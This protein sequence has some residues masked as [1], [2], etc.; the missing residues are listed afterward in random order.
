M[1]KSTA[2]TPGREQHSSNTIMG[3]YHDNRDGVCEKLYQQWLEAELARMKR[4]L[5]RIVKK[6]NLQVN[7]LKKPDVVLRDYNQYPHKIGAV[8]KLEVKFEGKTVLTPIYVS[9]DSE[10]RLTVSCIFGTNLLFSLGILRES[11]GVERS[12]CIRKY[13]SCELVCQQSLQKL[14]DVLTSPTV[15]VYLDFSKPFVLRTDASG[16]GL[17]AVLELIQDDGT[18][19]SIAYA[20]S[21]VS[22]HERRYGI[23]ELEALGAVRTLKH[24]RAHIWGH[25]TT[26]YT[27]HSL[28]RSLFYAKHSCG[29][30]ARWSKAVS[31]YDLEIHYRPGRQNANADA[32]FR[33]PLQA[34]MGSSSLET[35]QIATILYP[36]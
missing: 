3:Q 8:A 16:E 22:P 29:K 34:N 21:T 32:M 9:V 35:I 7:T 18:S 11:E 25:K 27:D 28:V 33:L 17:G 10:T 15:L 23:T 24:F 12:Y 26:L 4:T 1:R 13:H 14:H 19:H 6:A 31:E 36:N 5:Q 20:S 2:E 30:L